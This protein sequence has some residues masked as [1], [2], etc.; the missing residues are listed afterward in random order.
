MSLV[1]Q[2][3]PELKHL[4]SPPTP[5]NQPVIVI[6]DGE[7]RSLQTFR[8]SLPK[9]GGG[10]REWLREGRGWGRAASRLPLFDEEPSKKSWSV[11]HRGGSKNANGLRWAG[12]E[13]GLLVGTFWFR[14]PLLRKL[15]LQLK[16]LLCLPRSIGHRATSAGDRQSQGWSVPRSATM[17][18]VLSALMLLRL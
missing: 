2:P 14:L 6:K 7:G 3:A 16:E 18:C 15:L 8:M 17:K 13:L 9:V 5:F 4:P 1:V 12:L 11:S 10:R